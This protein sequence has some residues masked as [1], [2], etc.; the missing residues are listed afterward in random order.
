VD[1]GARDSGARE[2][3]SITDAGGSAGST[4]AITRGADPTEQTA[5]MPGPYRVMRY[6]TGVAD[7]PDYGGY[8]VD[9]PADATPPFAGVASI[10]GFIE[11]RSAVIA[12]GPF[13]ASHGFAVITVDPNSNLD[14]PAS[15]AEALW[16]AVGS[17]KAE[18]TRSAGPLF[19]KV[20]TTRLAVMGHSMG[21]GGTLQ[22][23]SEH[24]EL[25]AALPLEP[26]HSNSSSFAMIRVPTMIMAGQNDSVA[27]I[28]QHATPFYAAIPATTN[29]VYV[30]FQGGSH[31]VADDPTANTTAAIL[32]LS[33]FKVHLE[34]D[35]RYRPFIKTRMG[36]SSFLS[37]P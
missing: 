18:N 23:A 25:K 27:P 13:L 37:S 3:G 9:Y 2:S 14:S 21:G 30:E 10:P 29:K 12:W 4:G 6:S 7:S 15:R 22:A 26:W 5:S 19:G 34:G 36:L 8:D 17:L 28:D 31:F 16:A 20:D 11:S 32:G 33:W 1:S 35:T 24:P